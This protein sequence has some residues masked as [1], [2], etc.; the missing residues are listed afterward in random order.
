M[1]E[2]VTLANIEQ[3]DPSAKISDLSQY[4]LTIKMLSCNWNLLWLSKLPRLAYSIDHL[5]PSLILLK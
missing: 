5:F 2:L 4:F 3:K 1:P